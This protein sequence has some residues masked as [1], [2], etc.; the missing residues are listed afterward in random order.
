MLETAADP[1]ILDCEFSSGQ[2]W[3]RQSAAQDKPYAN[4]ATHVPSRVLKIGHLVRSRVE[5][6]VQPFILAREVGK[7]HKGSWDLGQERRP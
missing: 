3:G 1:L 4:L 2:Q 6:V 7:W 5:I